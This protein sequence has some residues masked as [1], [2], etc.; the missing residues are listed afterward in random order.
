MPD[1]RHFVCMDAD[2]QTQCCIVNITDCLPQP[3]KD[4]SFDEILAFKSSRKDE[5][6]A[7][8]AKIREF[9]TSIY[10]ADSVESIKHYEAQFVESW[11]QCSSDYYRVLKEAKISCFLGSLVCLY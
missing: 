1:H 10:N 11:K 9:E 5:L 6:N 8:R 4:V 7:F 2:V 3:S